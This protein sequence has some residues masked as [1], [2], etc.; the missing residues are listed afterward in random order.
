MAV[1][2]FLVIV[3]ALSDF[4][5]SASFIALSDFVTLSDLSLSVRKISATTREMSQR[6]SENFLGSRGFSTERSPGVV[7]FGS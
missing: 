7:L 5:H 1:V 4:C 2:L 6:F 3:V